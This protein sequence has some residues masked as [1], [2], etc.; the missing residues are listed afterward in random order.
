MIKTI[1]RVGDKLVSM[2]GECVVTD[3]DYED[4][5]MRIDYP[6]G[7]YDLLD[8]SGFQQIDEPSKYPF[9]WFPETGSP[10]KLGERPKWK[11]TKPTWCW[12]WDEPNSQKMLRLVVWY[13]DGLYEALA[14]DNSSPI[15]DYCVKWKNAEPCE[16]K[17]I[18]DWWP[19]K[20]NA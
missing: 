20:N 4:E 15:S 16:E 8:L 1:F 12:V 5:S 9:V 18:P 2:R 19:N 11:P 13:D 14:F 6:E 17:Y 10:P 7:G 3:I